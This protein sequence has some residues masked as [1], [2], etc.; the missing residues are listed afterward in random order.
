MSIIK[1][2]GTDGEWHVLNNIIPKAIDV[3][4]T[5]GTSSASVMSQSAVTE[6]ISGISETVESHE[7]NINDLNEQGETIAYALTDLNDRVTTVTPHPSD[8]SLHIDST[9]KRNLDSLATNIGAISGFTSS[10]K[11]KLDTLCRRTIIDWTSKG[12]DWFI[13]TLKAAVTDGSLE[14]YGLK[15]GDEITINGYRYII[16]ELNMLQI[17]SATS[18]FRLTTNHVGIIVSTPNTVP[19][20][21]GGQVSA[22]TNHT[23][24]TGGT[25]TTGSGS[26]YANSDLHYYL[27]NTVL[28]HVKTDLG[29]SNIKKVSKYYSYSANTSG[30]D[31][32]GTATGCASAFREYLDQEICALSEIQ[33]YG[34]IVWSSS[35]YDAGEANRQLEVFR[36]YNMN[37]IFP[38]TV[39]WLRDIASRKKACVAGNYGDTTSTD[40]NNTGRHAVG[41][42]IFA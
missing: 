10:D 33:V 39:P 3:T 7:D 15:V 8:S 12:K 2:K 9:E 20:N 11:L 31:R 1:Y 6:I 40:V 13:T 29:S 14:K 4:Q 38:S 41:L 22:S 21:K 27:T 18:K 34:S 35:A 32:F 16:A 19:W 42:I 23:L 28:P 17:N 5:S 37:E 24:S 25:W 26:C 36:V 30:Y